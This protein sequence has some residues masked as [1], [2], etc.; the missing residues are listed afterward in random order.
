MQQNGPFETEYEN[1]SNMLWELD[2]EIADSA[3]RNQR[4]QCL[5]EAPLIHKGRIWGT[6]PTGITPFPPV[7]DA[8]P[9]LIYTKSA[10]HLSCMGQESFH[11]PHRNGCFLEKPRPPSQTHHPSTAASTNH[12]TADS[13][14]VSS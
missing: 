1:Q 11:S 13:P 2:K 8:Y 10:T 12:A 14:P 6:G 9:R 5:Y 3:T 7:T 4:F